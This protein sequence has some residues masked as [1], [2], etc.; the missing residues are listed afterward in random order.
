MK[1]PS[2][3]KENPISNYMSNIYEFISFLFW[4]ARRKFKG[5]WCFLSLTFFDIF[6]F[7]SLF[8][9]HF[10]CRFSLVFGLLFAWHCI[11]FSRFLQ[12]QRVKKFLWQSLCATCKDLL[13]KLLHFAYIEQP[14][15]GYIHIYVRVCAISMYICIYDWLAGCL[16][17]YL[18]SCMFLSTLLYF[19]YFDS[20][21]SFLA[22][23]SC[24]SLRI[25]VT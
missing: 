19:L 8:L 9:I 25:A 13:A 7:S 16:F 3:N 23:S 14:E 11:I 12:W 6:R 20:L 4:E 22:R 24:E 18:C 17:V 1:T 15:N 5:I 2:T 10:F 21:F